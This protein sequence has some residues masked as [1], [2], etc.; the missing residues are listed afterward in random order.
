MD[1]ALVTGAFVGALTGDFDG[2]VVT[3]ALD[4]ALVTGAFVGAGV[5]GDLDGAADAT[6]DFNFNFGAECIVN[7]VFL[8]QMAE[9]STLPDAGATKVKVVTA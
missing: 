9:I 2:A 7:V 3:G 6:L 5:T 8:P 1:G 4:G